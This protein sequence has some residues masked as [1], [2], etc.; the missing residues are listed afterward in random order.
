MDARERAKQSICGF[1]HDVAEAAGLPMTESKR[2]ELE[3]VLDL[4]IDD[5]V[6]IAVD[7]VCEGLLYGLGKKG[8]TDE[9]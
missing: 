3:D 1:L 4:L 8:G 5:A 2:V 9:Q 6:A 7:E